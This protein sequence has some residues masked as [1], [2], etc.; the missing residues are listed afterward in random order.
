[1]V[2]RHFLLEIIQFTSRNGFKRRISLL[3]RIFSGARVLCGVDAT[4]LNTCEEVSGRKFHRIVFNFPYAGVKSKIHLNRELMS[5]FFVSC[6][7]ILACDGAIIVTLCHGQGGTCFD[8]QPKQQ[9]DT[10]QIVEMAA[11]GDLVLSCVEPWSVDSPLS[12]YT[13]VGR[14]NRDAT[15]QREGALVHVFKSAP[16]KFLDLYSFSNLSK[17]LTPFEVHLSEGVIFCSRMEGIM[18][19]RCY[20]TYNVPFVNYLL[21]NFISHCPYEIDKSSLH[22]ASFTESN[23]SLRRSSDLVSYIQSLKV[24]YSSNSTLK[25]FLSSVFENVFCDFSVSPVLCYLIVLGP[26][27]LNI[28]KSWLSKL[29][30]NTVTFESVVST[31]EPTLVC[32]N[33]NQIAVNVFKIS[34]WRELWASDSKVVTDGNYLTHWQA[35]SIS[36]PTFTFDITLSDQEPP[37]EN[38]VCQVLWQLIGLMLQHVDVVDTYSAPDGWFSKCFRLTYCSYETPLYRS[39]VTKLQAIIGEILELQLGLTVR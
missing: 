28:C 22:V 17:A 25:L 16:I 12:N 35:S 38:K 18:L 33:I 39:R 24:K 5:K 9:A 1:M 37:D 19:K 4:C 27:A 10:W 13:C 21:V 29:L 32:M 11:H 36:P 8:K 31:S 14:R 26:D 23:G 34:N 20:D 3:P 2:L 30:S 7:P 15:F 6:Y